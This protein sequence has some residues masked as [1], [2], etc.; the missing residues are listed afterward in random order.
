[1]TAGGWLTIASGILVV[2]S[3]VGLLAVAGANMESEH[4]LLRGVAAVIAIFIGVVTVA[5]VGVVVNMGVVHVLGSTG[6]GTWL[7][8]DHDAFG[9]LVYGAPPAPPDGG[10][11]LDRINAFWALPT[12]PGTGAR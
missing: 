10:T 9:R 1:M 4:A 5:A 2:G 8:A 7:A 3:G 11:L 12:T 6:F